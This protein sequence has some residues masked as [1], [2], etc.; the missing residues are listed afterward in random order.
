V[1]IL[2]D[3]I[4]TGKTLSHF[5]PQLQHQQPLSIKICAL[6]HKAEATVFPIKPDLTG[7][8]I[9]DKFVLGYG[10]D[11]DGYGR[12]IPEIYQLIGE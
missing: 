11:Y 8:I 12:N 10:L 4:D 6:L 9:P 5:I 2:E 7:F 3:I 1:V